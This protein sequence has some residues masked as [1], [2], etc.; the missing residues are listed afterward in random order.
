MKRLEGIVRLLYAVQSIPPPLRSDTCQT[1]AGVKGGES[2][3]GLGE[4]GESER[5]GRPSVQTRPPHRIAPLRLR[6][7]ALGRRGMHSIY[8]KSHTAARARAPSSGTVGR[9]A[10]AANS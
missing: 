5:L 6:P 1:R 8:K 10:T 7:N 3:R 4:S 9:R 2:D